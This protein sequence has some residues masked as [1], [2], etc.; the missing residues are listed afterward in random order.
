MVF[1]K[2]DMHVPTNATRALAWFELAAALGDPRG[3]RLAATV[4]FKGEGEVAKDM[5]RAAAL[6]H[7]AAVLGDAFSMSYYGLMHYQGSGVERDD[8]AAVVWVK[9]GAEAGDAMGMLVYAVMFLEGRALTR[10]MEAALKWLLLAKEHGSEDATV[11][12][13]VPPAA[14]SATTIVEFT[15]RASEDISLFQ[16]GSVQDTIAASFATEVSVPSS[17]SRRREP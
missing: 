17:R 5:A 9:Q 2:G 3:L 15:L 14:N 13:V 10:D 4:L 8:E 11:P 6:F 16:D 1:Y 12:A 7:K